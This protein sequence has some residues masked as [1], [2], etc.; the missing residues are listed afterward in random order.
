M[1]V[2]KQ[3]VQEGAEEGT[4]VIADH[5]TAGRGRFGRKWLE[6]PDSSILLSIILRPTLEELFADATDKPTRN[7]RI[8]EA[9]RKH[10]Y[11]L[12]QV[13]DHLGLCYSTISVIAK[14]VDES[15]KP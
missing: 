3:A 13:G 5:Q 2:A 7:E 15:N 12:K 14:R 10:Q 1:D 9:V 6:P 8:H 4:I 11:R